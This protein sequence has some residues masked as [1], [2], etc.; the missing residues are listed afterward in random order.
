MKK[1]LFAILM[2]IS[3]TANSDCLYDGNLYPTGAI[4]GG[5]V[6]QEDGT[7]Q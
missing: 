4:I 2:I 3:F 6:C 1:L 7:W 5:M